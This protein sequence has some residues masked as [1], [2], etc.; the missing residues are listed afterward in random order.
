MKK[1]LVF[2]S[3]FA[4]LMICLLLSLMLP[5]FTLV[6]EVHDNSDEYPYNV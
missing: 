6:V 1:I 4:L 5:I 3:S 2:V